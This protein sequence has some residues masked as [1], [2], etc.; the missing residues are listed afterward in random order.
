MTNLFIAFEGCEGTGKT[1]QIQRL[2]ETLRA[3]GERVLVTREPGGTPLGEVIRGWLQHDTADESPVPAAEV[4]LFAAS[5]AQHVERVIRPALADGQWV[6]C[7]R[8]VASS[9]AYQGAGRE[10]G[11]DTIL[12]INRLATADLLPHRTFL[13]D[14]DVE[15]ALARVAARSPGNADRFEKEAVAFH[16]RVRDAYLAMATNDSTFAVIN[17][18]RDVEVIEKEIANTLSLE[19]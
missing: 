10:F 3:R 2:A 6:L 5:R 1:T 15:T 8:F 4:Y 16:Q 9:A 13:L 18:G 12:D 7:D 17:A 14:L 19:L 11:P